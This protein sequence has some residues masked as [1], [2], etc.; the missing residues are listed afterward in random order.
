M[1]KEYYQKNKVSI[2]AAQKI[3]Y[4][5]NKEKFK[6]YQRKL[7]L[8][9]TYFPAL[10]LDGAYEAYANLLLKQNSLCAICSKPESKI[11]PQLGKPCVLAVDHCHVTGKV[12]GLLCFRCN[13]N[14]G[15]YENMKDQFLKYLKDNNE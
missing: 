10:S 4:D 1:T 12:R 11:D 2:L 15:W 3:R 7:R 9:N 13:T 14:L 5:A 8:R 6:L